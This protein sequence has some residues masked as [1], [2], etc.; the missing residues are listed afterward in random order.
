MFSVIARSERQARHPMPGLLRFAVAALAM[1]GYCSSGSRMNDR[2]WPGVATG[3]P[4]ASKPFSSRHPA[5]SRAPACRRATAIAWSRP[6]CCAG[7][8]GNSS[9][10]LRPQPASAKTPASAAARATDR[11]KWRSFEHASK[12]APQTASG[13]QP[14]KTAPRRRHC[15]RKHRRKALPNTY[16]FFFSRLSQRLAWRRTLFGAVPP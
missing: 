10:P 9:G 15:V 8:G 14:I 4:W 13:S 16:A 12:H 7:P 6:A 3:L 2:F 1:T 5:A 11:T